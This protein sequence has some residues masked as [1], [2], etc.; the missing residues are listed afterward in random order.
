MS[1]EDGPFVIVIVEVTVNNILAKNKENRQKKNL[2]LVTY[3][4]RALIHPPLLLLLPL[5]NCGGR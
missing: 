1:S 2:M 3:A 4:S 5:S